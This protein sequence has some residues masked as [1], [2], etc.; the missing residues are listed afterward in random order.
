MVRPAISVI[1]PA[2]DEERVLPALVAAL[3]DDALELVVVPN[4]CTD[5]TADVARATVPPERVVEIPEASKTAALRAGE[6]AA[7]HFPRF[8]LDADV[9][10]TAAGL[11]RLA[12]ALEA[13]G[14]LAVAPHVVFDASG[15]SWPVRAFYRALPLLPSV[16]G[17]IAGTGC[18]GLSEVGRA[19]F[20]DWPSVLADDYFVDGLFGRGEKRRVDGV[21]SR[22]RTPQRLGDLVRR[23]VRVTFGNRQVDGLGLR[24]APPA[25]GGVLAAAR[26][27]PGR[28][29]D[30]AV[31]VAVGL[32][33]R[34]RVAA[35]IRGGREVAWNRDDSRDA[36]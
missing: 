11:R 25:G 5:R 14:V 28:L 3:D 24:V 9:A 7:H 20:G 23:R 31:F 15:A 19:R 2:H 17:S 16:S 26:R 32:V 13:P 8:Y 27:H 10:V 35:A 22:V 12:A 36:A 4:G 29:L 6:A 18:I 21:T 1:V 34:L 33:V 30:L